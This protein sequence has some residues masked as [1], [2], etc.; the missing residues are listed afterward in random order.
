LHVLSSRYESQSVAVLEAALAGV[1]TVGTC[2]GL[3]A[4][5]APEAA[6]VVPIG[7][8]SALATRIEEA[9]LDESR[10]LALASVAQRYAR[11]HDA[12]WTASTFGSLYR[13]VLGAPVGV[14]GS[15]PTGLGR[16]T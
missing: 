12:G 8:A 15:S 10:R 7:D 14:P 13:Q 5:L 16:E 11:S 9:L 2:V 1:A 3:L 4:D 6:A